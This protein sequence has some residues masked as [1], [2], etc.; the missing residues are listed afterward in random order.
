M[1]A[2][3]A[4]AARP[5]L[6]IA[7]GL[8]LPLDAT[9]QKLAF[10]GRT[11]SGKTYAAGKVA[12]EMLDAGAQVIALDPVGVWY[13]L[14]IAADGRSPGIKIPVFGGLHGDVPLEPT[15]GAL[16]ADLICDRGI[17]AVIDVSQFESDAQKCRFAADFAARLFFRKKAA[18]SALMLFLEECQEFIPQNPERE[19]ARMLHDFTRLGKIGRNFGIGLAL[20][21][22]RPQEVN[23]KVLNM[24]ECMFAF[25][26]TGPHERKTI[27]QWVEEKGTDLDI[28]DKLPR[29]EVGEC[30]VWSPQ[31]LKISETV[32]IAKKR[33]F[34]ASSTPSV[35]SAK[36]AEPK[37]LESADLDQLRADM[38][39]TIERAK[40][41]DV[42]ELQKRIRELER[43]LA[44][45]PAAPAAAPKRVEVPILTDK[46]MERLEKLSTNI[47]DIGASI[48]MQVSRVAQTLDHSATVQIPSSRSAVAPI[49][50]ATREPLPSANAQIGS[51]TVGERAILT[52]CAQHAE[53]GCAREQLSILC[54]YKRSSRD[55]YIQQLTARKLVN[56][57]Y[58]G[59]FV[60]SEDGIRELGPSFEPLP[61]GKE[62]CD[63]WIAR[64][65]QGE[66]SILEILI[67]VFP[68][69]LRREQIDE[70]GYKRSARDKYLQ[71]LAARKLITIESRGEVRAAKELF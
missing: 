57:A 26:M 65:P 29:F 66:R 2:M 7:P 25:Q 22:Q 30:H 63:Y 46:Q 16:L 49:Q 43:E 17:S 32:R 28:V 21:S 9:T 18:P 50:S 36:R 8:D 20:I 12:E 55:K 58:G 48:L 71:H 70:A 37:P 10:L 38:A 39:A 24:T 68:S 5:L 56:V 4:S 60:A 59:R 61:T 42:G 1:S 53:T 64:L 15:G 52:A 45:K 27:R 47:T 34:N 11:G 62:L 19:E 35:G 51:L 44:K 6:R 67:R 13:G 3:T 69:A 23:K 41:T 33:T 54:G 40:A 31:W 14:R